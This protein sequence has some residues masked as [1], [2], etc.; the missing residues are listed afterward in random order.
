M[1]YVEAIKAAIVLLNF[2]LT[3]VEKKQSGDPET[4]KL[5]GKLADII[6]TIKKD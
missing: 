1:Q 4:N 3:F 5:M 6:E 2:I